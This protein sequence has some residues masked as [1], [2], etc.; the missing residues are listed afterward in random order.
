[1]GVILLARETRS[2]AQRCFGALDVTVE[3]NAYG[4]QLDSAIRQLTPTPAAAD[5]LGREPVECVLLRAPIIREA[6]DGVRTL[7]L[8]GEQPVLVE[9]GAILGAT[10]HPELTADRRIHRLFVDKV[11][12]FL[13]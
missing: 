1:A 12:A 6:G 4:R 13:R 10:F 11:K 5:R 2:P 8:A 7:L 3:R 9:Q